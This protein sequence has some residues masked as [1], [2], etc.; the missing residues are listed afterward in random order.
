MNN[1]TMNEWLAELAKLESEQPD[2]FT[3][4]ELALSQHWS[5]ELARKKIRG[6]I[7]AGVIHHA[8]DRKTTNIAGKVCYKPVYKS[9]QKKK[10]GTS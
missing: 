4:D 3:A 8:G 5:I 6:G 1:I 10:R 2:G 7:D 9:V